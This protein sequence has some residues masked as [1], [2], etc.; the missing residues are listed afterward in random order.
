MSWTD[1]RI[2][3]LKALWTKGMTASQIAEELGG[4]S[5]NAVIGKAHRLGLQSRPSP[6]KANEPAPAAKPKAKAS[7]RQ[8]PAPAG[9]E[10]G[11]RRPSRRRAPEPPE[12]APRRRRPPRRLPPPPPA[13][14]RAAAARPLDRPGR[15]RPPGPGRPAG[16]DPA[17]AA[18]PPGPG[19]AE[20]RNRRQDRPARS[21]REDLQMAD[22]PSRR[23]RFPFLRQAGQSRLPL[24]RRSIAASPIR[25][26]SR[27]ATASRRRPCRSAAPGCA[28]PR[29]LSAAAGEQPVDD[30]DQDRAARSRRRSRPCRSRRT[31]PAAGRDSR[32]ATAPPMPSRMVTRQPPGSRP[33]TT[34]LRDRAGDQADED[35][36]EPAMASQRYC[37]IALSF[38]SRPPDSAARF[39]LGRDRPKHVKRAAEHAD[40]GVRLALVPSDIFR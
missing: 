36:A 19:Q 1:E 37:D 18:A 11:A 32:R 13:S 27:A 15:L 6:V 33:G 17:R 34:A 30:Q 39:P 23:A 8:A 5:R 10:G 14:R 9:R 24:L 16:A 28:E 40:R 2:D 35:P 29:R 12:A 4:V 26:S 3:R 22:R 21:Q 20:P 31:N 7:R 38:Q 25:R